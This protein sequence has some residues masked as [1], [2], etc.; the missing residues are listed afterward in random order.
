MRRSFIISSSGASNPT[1][2]SAKALNK[3]SMFLVTRQKQ[4]KTTTVGLEAGKIKLL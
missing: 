4:P 1:L 2:Q 3:Y